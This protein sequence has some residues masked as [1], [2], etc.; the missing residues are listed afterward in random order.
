MHNFKL[1]RVATAFRLP[2]S[3]PLLL[4]LG[5]LP[6]AR[7]AEP[8]RAEQSACGIEPADTAASSPDT[9]VKTLY[10]IVSGP[11]K[12]TKDWARLAR[13]HAPG[14]LIT[15]TQHVNAGFAA[16]PQSLSQFIEL[17]KRIFAT[18][19]FH[20]RETSHRVERF[21]H[22]AHVW[23]G[24]ETREHPGGPVQARGLNSFQLLNDGQRWCVLSATWDI[25]SAEHPLPRADGALK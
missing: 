25:D 11:A 8:A 18:R 14:A 4:A 10:D 2:A 9:L 5:A 21:G 16:A 24:Y 7:A 12:A 6:S 3:L 22:I 15:P 17:N 23:S 19:G 1:Y 20:E 13:L